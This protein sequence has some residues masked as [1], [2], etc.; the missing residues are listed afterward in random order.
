MGFSFFT[1]FK[2]CLKQGNGVS[3]SFD[4]DSFGLGLKDSSGVFNGFGGWYQLGGEYDTR[5]IIE[6][7]RTNFFLFQL[8]IEISSSHV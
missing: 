2:A 1:H 7:K 3:F 8:N 4:G 6:I 5:K